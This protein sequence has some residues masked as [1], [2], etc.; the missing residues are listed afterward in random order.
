MV[1]EEIITKSQTKP[2]QHEILPK[3]QVDRMKKREKAKKRSK[4]KGKK[5]EDNQNKRQ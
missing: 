3:T 4:T 1:S 2:E 5:T